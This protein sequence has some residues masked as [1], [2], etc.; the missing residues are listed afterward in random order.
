[1]L[2]GGRVDWVI[3]VGVLL[4]LLVL[5]VLLL[6]R[7]WRP[8]RLNRVHGYCTSQRGEWRR[9][10]LDAGGVGA[11]QR[12]ECRDCRTS[13]PGFEDDGTPL[14]ACQGLK[15]RQPDAVLANLHNRAL[16]RWS[17]YLYGPQTFKIKTPLELTPV[18]RTF[19]SVPEVCS[20]NAASAFAPLCQDTGTHTSPVWG[21]TRLIVHQL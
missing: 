1:L 6:R 8:D 11:R 4:M 16:L 2:G 7:W 9:G 21:R 12:L 20:S 13:S 18:A 17:T 14:E 15:W 19:P 10:Y 5:L 3:K